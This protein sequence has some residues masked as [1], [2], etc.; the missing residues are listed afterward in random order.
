MSQRLVLENIHKNF[1]SLVAVK[2]VNLTVEPG[3][4]VC[5][6]GQS[7]CGKTTLLRIITGFEAPTSG[8]I[9]YDKKIINNII[10]QK[11]DFGIV[12]QSYALFPNMT[13]AQNVA[14]GPQMRRM[15]KK[16]IDTRIDEILQLVGLTEWKTHYPAQLSGGQQQRVALGRALAIKPRVLLLDE[17]LSAL[18][19]KIRIHLRT[20]IKRLQKELGVTMIYVTHDQEEALSLADRVV[21]MRDGQIEQIGS[22][23]EIYKEPRSK[24][25]AE[26][27]GTSNFIEGKSKDGQILF[28]DKSF[29][30][31][32]LKEENGQEVHLA[33][34]PEK[35]RLLTSAEADQIECASNVVEV[36]TEVV[37]FLGAVVQITFMLDNVDMN[38][39][40]TEEEFEQHQIRRGDVMRLFFPPAAFH[41]YYM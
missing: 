27:V 32:G 9:R 40:I 26:F 10:P 25:V 23:W 38:I 15:P 20:V 4:F 28:S 21:I 16:E 8:T 22:P 1:G 34:R 33:I 29:E 31:T 19:A 7:G 37:T 41:I 3:E 12:F 6:L 36:Q 11:R 17:P 24:F 39:D 5:F 30:V 14:F 18:D 2:D 35:I 13:V